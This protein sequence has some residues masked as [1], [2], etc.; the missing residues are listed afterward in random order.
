LILYKIKIPVLLSDGCLSIKSDPTKPDPDLR[1]VI[2]PN[3]FKVFLAFPDNPW[4]DKDNKRLVGFAVYG[5]NAYLLL[6]E[7]DN[8][9]N[10][11]KP[12]TSLLDSL[13]KSG[14][15]MAESGAFGDTHRHDG[16]GFIQYRFTELGEPQ[17]STNS[18]ETPEDS[19]FNAEPIPS[20]K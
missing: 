17:T 15:I 4:P 11:V 20:A 10:K 6:A 12:N 3:E 1:E 8:A 18:R 19:K 2:R 14:E 5:Y 9:I 7:L 16:F 13:N